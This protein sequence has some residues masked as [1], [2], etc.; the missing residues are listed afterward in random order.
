V[1]WSYCDSV[2]LTSPAWEMSF[3]NLTYS[4]VLGVVFWYLR[5]THQILVLEFLFF[6]WSGVTLADLD[7]SFCCCI[8]F[9]FAVITFSK[10]LIIV[11]KVYSRT[12][13]T[14]KQSLFL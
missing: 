10:F 5:P 3:G 7:Y 2:K 6:L 14:L 12:S 8:V 11:H 1:S 9:V 13:S 4:G